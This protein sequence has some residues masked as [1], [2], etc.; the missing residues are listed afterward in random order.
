VHPR[1]P[2]VQKQ[3]LQE[4]LPVSFPAQP[5]WTVSPPVSLHTACVVLGV[6]GSGADK[7]PETFARTVASTALSWASFAST[8]ASISRVGS[9]AAVASILGVGS[10][11]AGV[12][13]EQASTRVP[14]STARTTDSLMPL[15]L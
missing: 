9:T 11:G 10:A 14:M 15:T 7:V 4:L 12:T 3:L 2:F 13:V 8:V 5:L 6:F 1:T